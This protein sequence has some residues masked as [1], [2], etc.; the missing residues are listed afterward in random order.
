MLAYYTPHHKALMEDLITEKQ[1]L[2]DLYD[3]ADHVT[4]DDLL[5][6]C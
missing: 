3:K 6:H 5:N 4:Y 1:N 2:S